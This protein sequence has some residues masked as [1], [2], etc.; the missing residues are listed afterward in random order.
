MK[1]L[2]MVIEVLKGCFKGDVFVTTLFWLH[3]GGE[4]T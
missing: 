2:K 4:A 3:L 1:I